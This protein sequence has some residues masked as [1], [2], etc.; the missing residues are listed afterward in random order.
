ML[1]NQISFLQMILS[2]SPILIVLVMMVGFHWGGSKAGAI[3]WLVAFFVAIF[4]FGA[5]TRIIAFSQARAVLLSLDVLYII[6]PALIFY[7][8][9]KESGAITNIANGL[10][11]L[12][13]DRVLQLLILAWVFSSFLQGAAGFGVPVAVVAPL[14]IGLGFSPL[15]SVVAVGI[16]HSW[17]VTFGSMSSSFNALINATNL[18]GAA[19]APWSAILLGVSCFLCGLGVVHAYTGFS[20]IKR[21]VIAITLIGMVMSAVQYLLAVNGLWSLVGLGTGLAGLAAASFVS[22]LPFYQKLTPKD[23]STTFANGDGGTLK[24]MPFL[25]AI[26]PYLI[27]ILVVVSAQLFKPLAI[28]LNQIKLTLDFPSLQTSNGW[29]IAAGQ[30]RNIG[31]FGHAGALIIYTSILSFLYF[32]ILGYYKNG[33]IKRIL[34]NTIQS[35]VG[36]SIGIVTM[37]GFAMI[38]E[39]SG[40]TNSIAVGLSQALKSIYPLVSPFIGVLGAFMTGSN[41][42]SNVVFA[43]LQKQTAVLLNLTVPVILA[44]QTTGGSLGGMIAPAKLIIGCSTAG[45]AGK[46]G[47]V[48]K[49]VL[50][51]GLIIPLIIGVI[52]WIATH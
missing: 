20:G 36:S 31:I 16:G 40:M 14:L 41:T 42:N 32:K 7:F 23:V 34:S 9:V 13:S 26:I 33:A 45:L 24:P 47:V 11:H 22:R 43:G 49:K 6:W 25:L 18:P 50:S 15:I 48:M 51:Y 52:T 27:L 39:S 3:G 38:M 46:E 44:A 4:F 12:T 5:D 28:V 35:G 8:V 29:S 21:G 30:G 17:S 2:F 10:V 37:I 19:L 1:E